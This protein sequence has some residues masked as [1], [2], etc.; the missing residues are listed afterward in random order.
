VLR[1]T[2]SPRVAPRSVAGPLRTQVKDGRRTAASVQGLYFDAKT[3]SHPAIK[4]A[5]GRSPRTHAVGPAR[6]HRWGAAPSGQHRRRPT[7]LAAALDP[8]RAAR[9]AL[10]SSQ[11]GCSP[12]Q[13][14]LRLCSLRVTARPTAGVPPAVFGHKSATGEPLVLPHLFPRQGSRRSCPIP[15]S[16]AALHAQGP[17]CIFLFLSR[18]FCVNGG[19]GCEYVETSRD[20]GVKW[21][22]Q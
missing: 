5:I 3:K 7:L 20:P 19:H 9:A 15:V 16:R 22:L 13:T 11:F 12:K 4:A 6:A 17:H 21:K 18:V 10:F 2:R 8:A 1:G 14:S